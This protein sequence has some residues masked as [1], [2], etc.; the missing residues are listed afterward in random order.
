VNDIP[1]LQL[2]YDAL[3][4]PLGIEVE[5]NDPE[6][7]RQKLYPLR[8]ADETFADLAFILSPFDTQKLWIVKKGQ[9]DEG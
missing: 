1:L 2:L 6:R 9:P 3:H 8:K 5:T 4:A 7:L